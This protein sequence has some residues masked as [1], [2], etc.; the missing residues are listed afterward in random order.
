MSKCIAAKCSNEGWA[1]EPVLGVTFCNT[2]WGDVLS[3]IAKENTRLK[4]PNLYGRHADRAK[5]VYFLK[6][7]GYIK[8]GQS[9]TPVD[10]MRAIRSGLDKSEIPEAVDRGK[11]ECIGFIAGGRAEEMQLHRKFE[12]FQ[13]K[14]EWFIA[15][16][17]LLDHVRQLIADEKGEDVAA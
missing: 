7:S 13:A 10:R 3:H 5:K 8:I 11:I 14:G 1:A 15:A 17:E 16:P 2:H 12:R 6:S 4:T 9:L